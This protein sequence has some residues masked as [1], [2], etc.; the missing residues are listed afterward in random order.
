MRA[1]DARVR[2]TRIV[3]RRAG[4]RR[5]LHRAR[6][7]RRGMRGAGNTRGPV[8]LGRVLN[9]DTRNGGMSHCDSKGGLH[10]DPAV[11][12]A[13]ESVDSGAE[14]AGPDR[15]Q[16]HNHQDSQ[17]TPWIHA[18]AGA[19]SAPPTARGPRHPSRDSACLQRPLCRSP[20]QSAGTA[21]VSGSCGRRRRD[22][23]GG[24]GV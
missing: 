20:G 10:V 13:S 5:R 12:D 4:R 1:G 22:R 11:L 2:E 24:C 6:R 8:R 23:R 3:A 18:A 21:A 15:Y 14:Y 16:S 9:L 17:R 7:R 19:L